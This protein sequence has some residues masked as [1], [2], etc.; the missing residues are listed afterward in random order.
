MAAHIHPQHG[1]GHIQHGAAPI[2][3]AAQGDAHP[4]QVR[5][6]QMR[7]GVRPEGTGE[8]RHAPFAH[9]LAERGLAVGAGDVVALQGLNIIL[10]D[11][12]GAGI[13]GG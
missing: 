6:L 1:G 5:K 7:A 11:A 12:H 13:C 4:A 2:A 9:G 8:H 3:G 10:L